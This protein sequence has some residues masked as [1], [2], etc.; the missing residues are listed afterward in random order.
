MVRTYICSII[1]VLEVRVFYYYILIRDA[2][3]KT[4]SVV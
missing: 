3:F 2:A 1:I 4:A